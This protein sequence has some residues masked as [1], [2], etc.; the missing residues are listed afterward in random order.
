[1]EEEKNI[2]KLK[3]KNV[4]L[5]VLYRTLAVDFFF[6]NA[7]SYLFLTIEKGIS[8]SQVLKLSSIYLLVKMIFQIPAVILIKKIGKKSSIVLANLIWIIEMLIIIFATNFTMLIISQI[9][10]RIIFCY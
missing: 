9:L 1:M 8:T 7:I 4:R 3:E 10:G 2:K 6:Y 5:Y